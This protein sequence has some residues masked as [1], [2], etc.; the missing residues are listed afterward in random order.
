MLVAV[1]V[2]SVRDNDDDDVVVTMKLPFATVHLN[3]NPLVKYMERI[4]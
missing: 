2:F 3:Y 4:W 1:D